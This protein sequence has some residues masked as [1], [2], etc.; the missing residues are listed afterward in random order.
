VTEKPQNDR[1]QTFRALPLRPAG[2]ARP[3]RRLLAKRIVAFF[4]DAF[5]VVVLMIPA[6]LMVFILGFI[7]LGLAWLIFPV[8]FSRSWRSPTSR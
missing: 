1:P 6:A 4:I 5:L 2:G 8:L 7:T 3:L